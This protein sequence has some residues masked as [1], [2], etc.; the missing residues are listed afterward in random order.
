MPF[1][2]SAS[3]LEEFCFELFLFIERYNSKS[4]LCLF[5][6]FPFKKAYASSKAFSSALLQTLKPVAA[7]VFGFSK[8]E[9]MLLAIASVVIYPVKRSKLSL[10][11]RYRKN[12]QSLYR[13]HHK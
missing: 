2:V 4:L 11:Q 1:G 12:S 7:S 8:S 5:V 6:C 13:R 9:T 10:F 3:Y